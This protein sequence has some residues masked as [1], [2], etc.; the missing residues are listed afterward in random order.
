VDTALLDAHGSGLP[1]AVRRR[2]TH[3][4]TENTRVL[5]AAAA[6]EAGDPNRTGA[7]MDAS[8]DS[9]RD[10]YE[11]SSPELDRLVEIARATD[12]VLGSRMTGAGFG[13]CTVTLVRRDAV[14]ALRKN[15]QTG[16]HAAFGRT[17]VLHIVEN[18]LQAGSMAC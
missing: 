4:I 12:G 8:H 7:L 5:E 17:P 3:V 16:Y 6:L 13:G 2:C 1:D 18:N 15:L 9:L 11:V 14:P 10:L